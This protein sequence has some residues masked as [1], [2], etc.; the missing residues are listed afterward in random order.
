[1]NVEEA[2]SRLRAAERELHGC[3]VYLQEAL[4]NWREA[5]IASGN[6]KYHYRLRG[7]YGD[8]YRSKLREDKD[9]AFTNYHKA[10]AEVVK[11]RADY[12]EAMKA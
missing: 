3:D 9:M 11:A 7:R 6:N 8:N 1:M 4:A 12:E 10:E 5:E 2:K